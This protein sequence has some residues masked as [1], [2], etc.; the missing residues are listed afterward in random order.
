VSKSYWFYTFFLLFFLF[1]SDVHAKSLSQES[2]EWESRGVSKLYAN[3]QKDLAWHETYKTSILDWRVRELGLA[4]KIK[5]EGKK[6]LLNTYVEVEFKKRYE[7]YLQNLERLRKVFNQIH[8]SIREERISRI[9]NANRRADRS[10]I[11]WWKKN[12]ESYDEKWQRYSNNDS[13]YWDKEKERRTNEFVTINSLFEKEKT[14]E[15]D[16]ST[17]E[18]KKIDFKP[19]I[20]GR[21][22]TIESTEKH[23]KALL[24]ELMEGKAPKRVSVLKSGALS[25]SGYQIGVEFYY[26]GE[27]FLDL[28]A[29]KKLSS[30]L[31]KLA[32]EIIVNRP[33]MRIRRERFETLTA[34]VSPDVVISKLKRVITGGV[35]KPERGPSLS[36]ALVIEDIFG[37]P[38]GKEGIWLIDWEGHLANPAIKI[39]L[40]LPRGVRPGMRITL[41][42][43]EPKMYFSLPS[44]VG[45]GGPRKDVL[46]ENHNTKSVYVSVWPD[47]NAKHETHEI[48]LTYQQLPAP[49]KEIKKEEGKKEKPESKKPP[50]EIALGDDS[51]PGSGVGSR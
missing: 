22:F 1:I 16:F 3:F 28:E 11:S 40:R 35:K 6:D 14:V 17:Y 47:R 24:K 10:R 15:F 37:R 8:K 38:I 32:V 36:S 51:D 25:W 45:N 2:R 26:P 19:L 5:E 49:I 21:R 23:V 9:R 46:L 33:N 43:K 44:K 34:R 41:R 30:D 18:K 13:W 29:Q 4:S 39:R 31:K 48:V 27:K 12:L 50:R 20:N 42:A 7:F